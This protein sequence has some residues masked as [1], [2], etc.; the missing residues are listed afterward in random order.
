MLIKKNSTMTPPTLKSVNYEMRAEQFLINE[1][2]FNLGIGGQSSI[3]NI[4][5]SIARSLTVNNLQLVSVTTNGV[6]MAEVV[7]APNGSATQRQM[8][9]KIAGSWTPYKSVSDNTTFT[10]LS[11]YT[12][13]YN[14]GAPIFAN[15]LTT[16]YVP[17][18]TTYVNYLDNPENPTEIS[19]NSIGQPVSIEELHFNPNA[20]EGVIPGMI[21]AFDDFLAS[22]DV[23]ID[24]NTAPNRQ[25]NLQEVKYFYNDVD[26][27]PIFDSNNQRLYC[28]RTLSVLPQPQPSIHFP[29]VQY[30]LSEAIVLPVFDGDPIRPYPLTTQPMRTSTILYSSVYQPSLTGKLAIAVFDPN[31]GNIEI[32]GIPVNAPTPDFTAQAVALP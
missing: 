18:Q 26:G 5:V 10:I 27:N 6:L 7:K 22:R 9:C 32:N 15:Q 8:R 29:G 20:I 11:G 17:Q 16:V 30:T 2:I 24:I 12:T 3:S 23:N 31:G 4:Q 14:S 25:N 21:S 13:S 1:L 28:S 19:F